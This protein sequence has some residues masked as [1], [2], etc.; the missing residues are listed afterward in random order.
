MLACDAC[1]A[2]HHKSICNKNASISKKQTLSCF[3]W[4]LSRCK[5]HNSNLAQHRG[6]YGVCSRTHSDVTTEIVVISFDPHYFVSCLIGGRLES[7][8]IVE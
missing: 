8:M 5:H 1:C 3:C 7:C 4:V 2:G 6:K